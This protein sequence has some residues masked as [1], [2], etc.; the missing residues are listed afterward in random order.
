M[1]NPRAP[2]TRKTGPGR[3]HISGLRE[4]FALGGCTPSDHADHLPR[5]FPGAKLARK[6]LTP[7]R[8]IGDRP[9]K[10]GRL[11]LRG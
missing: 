8:A 6:A 1:G 5:G 7:Q 10:V 4:V 9:A 11:T 2:H 3:R